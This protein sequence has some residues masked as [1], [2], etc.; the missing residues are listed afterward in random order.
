MTRTL[1]L[2]YAS[3]CYAVGFGSLAYAILF[4]NDLGPWCT[5]NGGTEGP[6]LQSVLLNCALAMVFAV[7][8]S[9]MAR[10]GFKRMWTK[11]VPP[12]AE[13]STYVLFSGLALIL[14][15]SFWQPMPNAVWSL[16]HGGGRVAIWGVQ[17][18]GWVLLVGATF[19]LGHGLLFGTSQA[20]AWFQGRPLAPATFRTPALY[21]LVRHPIQLGVLIC[22]WATPDMSVGHLLL[23]GAISGYI[24]VALVFFEEPDLIRQFGDDYRDY[25]KRVG[26]LI[27]RLRS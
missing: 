22:F 8:H 7:Q 18:I 4:L 21:R 25:R 12:F 2:A 10:P 23:C 26:M 3:L 15:Y 1:G 19:M 27:P 14:L 13:R 5:I 20:W 16:E 17:A 9:V 11:L 24:V 6:I